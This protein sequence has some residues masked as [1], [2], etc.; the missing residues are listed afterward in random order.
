[1]EF[2]NCTPHDIVMN[3]GRVFKP[4]GVIPRVTQVFSDIVDDICISSFGEITGLPEPKTGVMYI[5]SSMVM[6]ASD[7]K[8]LVAPATSHKDCVREN[9]RIVS[10]PCFYK[11]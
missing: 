7:R 1:M 10:V 4:S 5:V 8:D 3:D 9:G 11:E 6:A 2:I